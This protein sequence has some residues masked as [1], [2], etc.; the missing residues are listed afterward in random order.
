MILCFATPCRGHDMWQR[1]PRTQ[2]CHTVCTRSHSRQ[3]SKLGSTLRSPDSMFRPI[4]SSLCLGQTWLQNKPGWA[5][6]SPTVTET[7][8]QGNANLFVKHPVPTS[9]TSPP[10]CPAQEKRTEVSKHSF[11]SFPRL[12]AISHKQNTARGNG[13]KGSFRK[14]PLLPSS[15]PIKKVSLSQ[16]WHLWANRKKKI[17]VGNKERA[18]KALFF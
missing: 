16:A 17:H 15:V 18:T 8:K 2:R 5:A 14:Y 7:K 10:G 3:A 11:L 9:T 13:M 6:D 4:Y 1:R 12:L